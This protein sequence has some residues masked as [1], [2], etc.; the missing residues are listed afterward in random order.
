MDINVVNALAYEDF[1]KLFG[2]VVEKCPLIS[3]AIWSYR[4]FKDLADIEARISEFI[5]SLPDSG[6]E[7]IL[8]C[9][10]DLA[11]RDL[12][13]GTL[14]PESQEEQSQA[15][16]TTLDSAEIVHMYRLNSEYK[17]RFGFPFVICARLNNKADI[18]RQLSERLKN[19]R[20]AELECAIEEVKKICSLRLHSIVLS[21]IQTKL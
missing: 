14:T 3:A 13:S 18:V 11:G 5:H 21:D 9:H 2:N 16:M 6:K 8:R 19:R 15:G 10:P 4:P 17:E 1:V 20:T 7:G 12:Q